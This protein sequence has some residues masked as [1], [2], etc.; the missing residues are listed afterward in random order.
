MR[1]LKSLWA[2]LIQPISFDDF[3]RRS[4]QLLS[5]GKRI[6]VPL[7]LLIAVVIALFPINNFIIPELKDRGR[8]WLF[9]EPT[10]PPRIQEKPIF[11]ETSDQ[12]IAMQTAT[13]PCNTSNNFE[14]TIWKKTDSFRVATRNQDTGEPE[15]LAAKTEPPYQSQMIYPFACPLPFI[16]IISVKI[17][18][19]GSIGL[20]YEYD[21][22]FQVILGDGDR[23]A[24]R[25]KRDTEGTRKSGWEYI[26]QEPKEGGKIITH[27]LPREIEVGSQVDL[28][29]KAEAEQDSLKITVSVD[30][31]AEESNKYKGVGF[32]PVIFSVKSFNT[33]KNIGKFSRVGINDEKFKGQQSQVSFLR[34][35]IKS[36]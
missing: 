15:Y 8:R 18:S 30:Y 4:G 26:R 28:T 21:G 24:I 1:K 22:V 10:P 17:K 14:P 9:P 20:H 23:R 31:K 3:K 11:P 19:K 6:K 12:V 36:E 16:T 7:W 25:Y 27:W 35:S 32:D 29:I 2:K 5:R 33:Q 13:T 34:F